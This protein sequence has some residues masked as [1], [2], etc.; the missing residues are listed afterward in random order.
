M[1]QLFLIVILKFSHLLGLYIK[2]TETLVLILHSATVPTDFKIGSHK[3]KTLY[4]D[5]ELSG[6]FDRIKD[7][8]SIPYIG[9]AISRQSQK[10]HQKR[11][12]AGKG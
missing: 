4:S 6:E 8:Y 9:G 5:A 2:A 1:F 11:T 7:F 10:A 12:R 3:K